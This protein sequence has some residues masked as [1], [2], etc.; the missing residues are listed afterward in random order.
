MRIKQG[1]V[2]GALAGGLSL[3][4]AA[5][6]MAGDVVKVANGA[7]LAAAIVSAN[8]NSSIGTIKCLT[9]AGCN[10]T[11]TL[12]TYTGSQSL[13]IN[14]R[15]STID[16]SGITDTDVFASVGGGNL[17][18][19]RLTII[20]GM[21]G[22]YVEL[23]ADKVSNQK[24]ELHR[25]TVRD[26]ALHGVYIYDANYSIAGVRLTV[27]AS[28]FLDNGFGDRDQHGINVKEISKGAI[29]ATITSSLFRGNAGDG[30]LFNEKGG[31]R[32][33]LTIVRSNF[34]ENG[35]NPD[36]AIDPEDGLDVDERGPGDI[37]LMISES[38]FNKNFDDG[39]DIDERDGGTIFSNLEDVKATKNHDQGITYDERLDGDVFASINNSTVTGNDVGSQNIDLRGEQSDE[40]DGT[41]T[42]ENVVVGQSS[43]SGVQLITVP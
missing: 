21:T 23:P 39:I 36:N 15:F 13:A 8:S 10:V 27:T 18:L 6:A 14:G 42:L 43:L 20:G 29:L 40:G 2:I 12:P 37:W 33:D 7:E 3:G 30:L 22:I 16:A 38:R 11:G 41:L 26:A 28:K 32:V 34:L 5:S 35:T 1:I 9:E 19:M 24:V 17:K 31:G 25:V 4:V